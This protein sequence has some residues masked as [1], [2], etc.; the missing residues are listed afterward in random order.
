MA[1]DRGYRSF[2]ERSERARH[3][4]PPSY[5]L[6][7]E[8]DETIEEVYVQCPEGADENLDGSIVYM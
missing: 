2:I 3:A 6:C 1:K 5:S 7:Q 8:E 4:L